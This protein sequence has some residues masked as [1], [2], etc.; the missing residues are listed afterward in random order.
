MTTPEVSV[1]IVKPDAFARRHDLI[2]RTLINDNN[3]TIDE[4][5]ILTIS[6]EQTS[7]FY[8]YNQTS[9][10]FPQLVDYV[11]S[12]PSVIWKVSGENCYQVLNQVKKQLRVNLAYDDFY[13]GFHSSDDQESAIRELKILNLLT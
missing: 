13:T 3:L 7:Q 2:A 4:E 9:E 10:L 1:F 6:R 12:G 11:S 5:F 8:E